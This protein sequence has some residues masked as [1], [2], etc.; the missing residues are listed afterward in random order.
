MAIV[1][2]LY[3]WAIALFITG[4]LSSPLFVNVHGLISEDLPGDEMVASEVLGLTGD[5]D[6]VIYY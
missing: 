6:Q 5:S 1:G 2:A 4:C 3:K